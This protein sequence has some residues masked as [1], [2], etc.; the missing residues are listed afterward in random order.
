MQLFDSDRRLG[1]S[2]S[3]LPISTRLSIMFDS[4]TEELK[5]GYEW[6]VKVQLKCVFFKKWTKY[7]TIAR[8]NP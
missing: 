3:D 7:S 1:Y 4:F 8:Y 2:A 6:E 5:I